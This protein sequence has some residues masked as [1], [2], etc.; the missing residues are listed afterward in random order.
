[1]DEKKNA[2][3]EKRAE[4]LTLK[5]RAGSM[6]NKQR[7]EALLRREKP[8]RVPIYS[9]GGGFSAVYSKVSLADLYKNPEASLAAQRRAAQ[10]FD[11]VFVP[12]IAYAAFGGWEFGGQI[13]WPEGEFDQAPAVTRHVAETPEDVMKLK[14]PDIPT[15]G[16]IPIH[17]RF[18]EL[19]S[20]ERLDNEPWNVVIQLEGIF[21]C[22][23][24]IVGIDR[25]SRWVLR[26]SEVAHRLMRL[27]TGFEIE[28]AKYWKDLFGTEGVLLWG[29]DP[30]SSNQIISPKTFETFNLP[31]RK[32]IH[33][34]VL[35]MGYQTIFMHICGEQNE[36]LPYWAQIPMGD[37]GIVSFGHEVDLEK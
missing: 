4:D 11:W 12:E 9:F 7:V 27:A 19:S 20:Q 24:N 29:G 18:F 25:L 34:K 14:I 28:M 21:T 3:V 8:D 16:I 33:Q 13:K 36:N 23:S 37:P 5:K 30:V 17:R 26:R 6:T 10:E 1:M 35:E 15:A 31:Y 32:E 2:S 22:A